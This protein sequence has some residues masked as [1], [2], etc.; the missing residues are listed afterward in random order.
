KTLGIL[1]MKRPGY[2]ADRQR[3]ALYDVASKRMRVITEQWDR[4]A[5]EIAWSRDGKTIFTSAD[6]I[7]NHAL[8]SIDVAS[9]TVKPLVE[10]GTN[11]AVRVAG[12]RLV[13]ARDTLKSPVELFTMKPDGSD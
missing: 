11:A 7:G 13:F 10:K 9:G 3:V 8:F 6:H 2:E 1:Q 5:S 12:D 4:S